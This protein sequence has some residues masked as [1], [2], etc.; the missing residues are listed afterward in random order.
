MTGK[1]AR[2]DLTRISTPSFLPE[3]YDGYGKWQVSWLTSLKLPSHPFGQWYCGLQIFQ[4]SQLREQLPILQIM[5]ITEFP[6]NPLWGT[7]SWIK[8]M[9]CILF[10]QSYLT[11]LQNA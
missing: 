8:G 1:A 4:G 5:R 6:I 7:I 9:D 2:R 10:Y 11:F 3:S